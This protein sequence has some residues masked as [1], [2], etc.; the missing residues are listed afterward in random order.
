[1]IFFE[2]VDFQNKLKIHLVVALNWVLEG[3]LPM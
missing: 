3:G 2:K 1:M